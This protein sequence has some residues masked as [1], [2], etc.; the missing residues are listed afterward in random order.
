MSQFVLL[1]HIGHPDDP[2]GKHFDLLLEQPEACE[3]WRLAEIP[4]AAGPSVAASQL[5][6]H[7]LVWLHKVEGEVSGGRG[8]A[9]RVDSGSYELR[10]TSSA[11]EVRV[12]QLSGTTLSGVLRMTRTKATLSQKDT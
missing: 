6:D 12:V 11:G 3:T 8:F 7:R 2:A 1:E 9:R 5:P 10:T 4:V